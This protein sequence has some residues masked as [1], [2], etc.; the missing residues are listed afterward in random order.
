MLRRRTM[1]L[2]KDTVDEGVDAGES[3]N[4]I[5]LENLKE[6]V[7]QLSSEVGHLQSELNAAKLQEFE[8]SEQNA[9]LI[10][11]RHLVCLL[12]VVRFLQSQIYFA[13]LGQRTGEDWTIGSRKQR[14]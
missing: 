5:D 7:K 2:D 3:G 9:N 1:M 6:S 13:G 4:D 11:V 12:R 14:T 8:T 10:Q